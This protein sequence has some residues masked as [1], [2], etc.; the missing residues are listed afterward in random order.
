M[1]RAQADAV[2][3]MSAATVDADDCSVLAAD[4]ALGDV[5]HRV[6]V[7]FCLIEACWSWA[8]PAATSTHPVHGPALA[9]L[10]AGDEARVRELLVRAMT[11]KPP[12]SYGALL[13][14]LAYLAVD[15]VPDLTGHLRRRGL[16][17][18]ADAGGARTRVVGTD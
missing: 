8:P 17:T 10:C 12:G 2:A 6:L 14:Q 7:A 13:V 5:D 1:P 18:A 4:L 16:S 15:L 3:L 11:G 9:A